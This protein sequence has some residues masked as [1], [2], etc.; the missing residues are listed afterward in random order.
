[1]MSNGQLI[2]AET[3]S[4]LAGISDWI[5]ISVDG[6]TAQTYEAIR[7]G[8]SWNKL[9]GALKVLEQVSGNN[10]Q[11]TLLFT[12]MQENH[13]ELPLVA[14]LASKL[15][16]ALAVHPVWGTDDPRQISSETAH[17][18]I[19]PMLHR[20]KRQFPKLGV[21]N[22]EGALAFYKGLE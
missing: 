20:L 2:D 14:E 22:L 21:Y 5:G 19:I 6:G 7:S 12:I 16:F 13:H 15:G 10:L 17:Q 18:Q 3:A 4:V 1:M 11:I 8:A 9:L